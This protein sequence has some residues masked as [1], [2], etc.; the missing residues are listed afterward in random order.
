[1]HCCAEQNW[2]KHQTHRAKWTWEL[3][4]YPWATGVFSFIRPSVLYRPHCPACTV[5]HRCYPS[6]LKD[7]QCAPQ[8]SMDL[9]FVPC[10]S[11]LHMGNHNHRVHSFIFLTDAGIWNVSN[12]FHN[13]SEKKIRYFQVVHRNCMWEE[14]IREIR[15][16]EATLVGKSWNRDQVIFS[17]SV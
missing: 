3:D 7:L 10:L 11:T 15:W 8:S 9:I 13:N 6:C 1:M 16:R 14:W 12:Y 4:N 5:P 2:L 17:F